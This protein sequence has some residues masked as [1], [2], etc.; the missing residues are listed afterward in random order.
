MYTNPH[1]VT[2][3]GILFATV[4]AFRCFLRLPRPKL[5]RTL[6]LLL[7]CLAISLGS[8]LF[9][10]YVFTYF[11]GPMFTLGL[12]P[13]LLVTYR[14]RASETF[15]IL[16]LS[17]GFSLFIYLL[18]IIPVAFV[19]AQ[20]LRVFE[21]EEWHYYLFGGA[22]AILM[23]IFLHLFFRLP[24]LKNGLPY[25]KAKG[26]DVIGAVLGFLF[27]LVFSF[28]QG[29]NGSAV[30]QSGS[31]VLMS[32]G[33]KETLKHP[34]AFE[35][36]LGPVY[37]VV[38]LVLIMGIAV[39][40]WILSRITREYQDRIRAREMQLLSDDLHRQM[41]EN[42]RLSSLLHRDNKLLLGMQLS[43]DEVLAGLSALAAAGD[44]SGAV[45]ALAAAGDV[46]GAVPA[47]AA[48]GDVSGTVPALAAAG[49][50]DADSGG[51][52]GSSSARADPAALAARAASL[53]KELSDLAADRSGTVKRYELEAMPLPKIGIPSADTQLAYMQKRAAGEGIF[54]DVV[55]DGTVKQF[56]PEN[57]EESEFV[58][59]LADLLEN[60]LHATAAAGGDRIFLY[61]GLRDDIFGIEVSD[62]GV[63][64]PPAVA[65]AYGKRRKTT[66]ADE[67][68]TGIGLMTTYDILS[69]RGG[70]FHVKTL[71]ENAPYKKTLSIR[72]DFGKDSF[73]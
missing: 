53:R 21:R 12:F 67:G 18:A 29:L 36:Y 22:I 50:A 44:V 66:R 32:E 34:E 59:L 4:T 43:V 46:S 23:Q 38:V 19:Q 42:D 28:L 30:G 40:V 33:I 55:S 27:L 45:P 54:L 5:S 31:P 68:G 72:F 47:L 7:A 16:M 9:T 24:R 25:L 61:V 17:F 14:R 58:T 15:L 60:A 6:L 8:H 73:E 56:V 26:L 39:L 70:S 1:V 63:P 71:P 2:D 52:G 48:A 65:E 20:L 10:H 3:T 62:T 64:F 35:K 49:S 51:S 57:L 69:R 13:L 41:S 37:M 11:L